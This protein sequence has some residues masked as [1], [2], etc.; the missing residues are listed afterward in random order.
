[1]NLLEDIFD[2]KLRV[3]DRKKGIVVIGE[4]EFL[5]FQKCEGIDGLLMDL[6]DDVDRVGPREGDVKEGAVFIAEILLGYGE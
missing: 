5:I 3:N 2:A 4:S 1:M 6:P